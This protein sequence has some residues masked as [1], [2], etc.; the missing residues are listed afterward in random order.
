MSGLQRLCVD[1]DQWV[2][3]RKAEPIP[4]PG[5]PAWTCRPCAA[6]REGQ[7]TGRRDAAPIPPGG[8]A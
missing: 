8:A 4:G 7:Y 6:I 5:A 3:E 1:C 2:D